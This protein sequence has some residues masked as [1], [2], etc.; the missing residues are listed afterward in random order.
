LAVT[1]SCN[2][3]VRLEGIANHP[4]HRTFAKYNAEIFAGVI[5][6]FPEPRV[7]LLIFA[8]GKIVMTGAKN[9][10]ILRKAAEW[11]YPLLQLFEKPQFDFNSLR[12]P[13]PKGK[14]KANDEFA[15]FFKK[16]KS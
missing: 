11:V 12:T 1:I 6:R 10:E 15:Q 7:T 2:F 14:P 8:S 9:R 16:S 5:Y 4:G 3:P 13:A